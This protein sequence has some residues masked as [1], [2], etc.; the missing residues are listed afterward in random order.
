MMEVF[1]AFAVLGL[2]ASKRITLS[3]IKQAYR[4]KAKL[5][6]PDKGG[7]EKEFKEL[8]AAYELLTGKTKLKRRVPRRQ[9]PVPVRVWFHMDINYATTSCGTTTGFTF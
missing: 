3:D 7:S 1:Q 9:Q 6:H 4:N 8:V 2:D 5:L